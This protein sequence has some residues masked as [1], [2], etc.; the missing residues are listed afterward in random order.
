MNINFSSREYFENKVKI[1]N[2]KKF[3]DKRGFFSESYIPSS[4]Q[5]KTAHY[6]EI[7][8]GDV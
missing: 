5:T 3:F 8:G 1:I 4:G 2:L 6:Q 7:K